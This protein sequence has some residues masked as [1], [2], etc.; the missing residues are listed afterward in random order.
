M[1][2][3]ELG[4]NL[5]FDN[6]FCF[7]SYGVRIR[8]E[9]DSAEVLAAA[10]E[11]AVKALLGRITPI[12]CGESEHVFGFSTMAGD[13]WCLYENGEE[14]AR[15]EPGD[16]RLFK[17][18]DSSVRIL[19]GEHAKSVV[20]VHAGVVGWRKRAII[21]P[22]DSFFG[23]TTLVAELVKCGA[24]YYSDEYAVLD[25]YGLV[26]PFERRLSLRTSGESIVE[27]SFS[28]EELGGTTGTEPLPVGCVL[29]TEYDAEAK[30]R[31]EMLS[32]GQAVVKMVPFTIPIKA[33]TDFVLKV[34][35]S[36]CMNA[37]IVKSPRG[38]AKEFSS[39]FL[40]FVDK[41]MI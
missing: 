4:R 38:E 12:D 18:F 1:V 30:W 17:F 13:D 5:L 23:K 25:E 3:K 34:L 21:I 27:T 2:K 41:T 7:E 10:T 35:R 24:E 20:F 29:L 28:A 32:P 11:T 31:P 39:F 33:N 8:I 22:A 40:E 37:I 15:G 36:A 9:T 19:V 14:L 6:V 26:H 16:R